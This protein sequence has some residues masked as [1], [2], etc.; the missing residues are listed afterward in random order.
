[1][2]SGKDLGIVTL[3]IHKR[4]HSCPKAVVA[5][6]QETGNRPK[7]CFTADRPPRPR[8]IET[9]VCRMQTAHYNFSTP[10]SLFTYFET[11]AE[12][13]TFGRQIT[14]MSDT[15]GVGNIY[16]S[17]IND[18]VNF[19]QTPSFFGTRFP[20]WGSEHR[21]ASRVTE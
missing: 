6:K 19:P 14:I 17:R 3:H 7:K 5:S 11:N 2:R 15:I 12:N 20:D 9:G 8:I 13:P 1:M 10:V 4:I 21:G 16:A 18:E